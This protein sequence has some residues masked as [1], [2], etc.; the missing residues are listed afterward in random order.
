MLDVLTLVLLPGMDGTGTLFA[1]F[2][3]A[4]PQSIKTVAVHYPTERY[5]S[6]SDLQE[7]VSAACP[8]SDPF[9]LV[10]ESFSTPLAIRY[11]ANHPANLKGLILCAGFVTSPVNGW[12]RH[13][14]NRLI[15]LMIRLPLSHFVAK[16]WL[17]GP[18][19][20]SALLAAVRN[21]ISSVQP[22]VLVA[23]LRAVLTSDA[24]TALNNVAVPLLYIRAKQD[25]LVGCSCLEKIR[26]IKPGMTVAA[27]DGP[28]LLL[29]REPQRTAEIIVNFVTASLGRN[30]GD[31]G[32]QGTEDRW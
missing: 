6:Y 4:L 25:R 28:H 10:A 21:V 8:D 20:P 14:A 16:R 32:V 12:K 26:Q 11:A 17:L 18:S 23:R 7:F 24:S 15:P 27:L 30:H 29:Q 5:L 31:H 2:V 9:V 22:S 1:D 3:K 13:V 19:A